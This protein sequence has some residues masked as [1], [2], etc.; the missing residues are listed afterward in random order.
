VIS[1]D[2]AWH[3]LGKGGLCTTKQK[4]SPPKQNEAFIDIEPFCAWASVV[5]VHLSP[6]NYWVINGI[7]VMGLN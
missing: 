2:V 7:K 4:Y 5:L 1:R 3:E 6:K